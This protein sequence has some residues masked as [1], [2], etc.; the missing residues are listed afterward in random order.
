MGI[1]W[2]LSVT[3]GH[4]CV[5]I[6]GDASSPR[7]A[8]E[9]VSL[10]LEGVAGRQVID[11]LRL[12]ASELCANAVQHVA[13]TMIDVRVDISDPRWWILAITCH[14]S[15]SEPPPVSSWHI[16]GAS[17]PSGRGLGIVR[18]LTDRLTVEHGDQSFV[19]TCWRSRDGRPE[20][21]SRF[22]V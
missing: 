15:G 10:R 3:A 5:S 14:T 6:P 20:R 9:W 11:D 4:E 2:D 12:V 7:R 13:A 16:A 18:R 22:E 21:T 1:G 17:A 19:V 8:R